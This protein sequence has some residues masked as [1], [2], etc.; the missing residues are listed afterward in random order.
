MRGSLLI[1]FGDQDGKGGE[2]IDVFANSV[3]LKRIYTTS[4]KLY[5]IPIY[6]GDVITLTLVNPVP[7]IT[8]LLDIVRRDY[9]TDDVNGDYGIKETTIIDNIVFTTYS[10]TATTV[11]D[12][13]DF[14]YLFNNT[15][16]TEFQIWTE[17]SEPIMTENNDYLNQEY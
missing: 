12:A 3:L 17:A 11:N 9:T 4:N 13:Y 16:I 7:N 2:Y 14:E 1:S 8:T 5:S 6:L 15:I 10:F